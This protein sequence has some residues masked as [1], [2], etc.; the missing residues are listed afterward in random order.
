MREKFVAVRFMSRAD[1]SSNSMNKL[2]ENTALVHTGLD[3]SKGH[4]ATP[5]SKPPARA[6][7][8]GGGPLSTHQTVAR[9]ARRP[10]CAKPP[11]ATNARSSP[12]STP[13]PFP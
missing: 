12:H 4:S 10:S 11:A 7:Q 2:N 8:H 3:I 13:P 1:G 6:A 5:P 9:G